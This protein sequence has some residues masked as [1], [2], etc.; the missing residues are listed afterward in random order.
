VRLA[1]FG[2]GLVLA[3]SAVIAAFGCST[4]GSPQP[5]DAATCPLGQSHYY[6]SAGCGT[7]APVAVCEA[8]DPFDAGCTGQKLV[9]TCDRPGPDAGIIPGVTETTSCAGHA[10]S[11]Y[12]HEGACVPSSDAGSDTGSTDAASSG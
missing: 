12:Q 2:S 10:K 8:D 9:C 5:F 1:S 7:T 11:P 6:T 4:S 3:F